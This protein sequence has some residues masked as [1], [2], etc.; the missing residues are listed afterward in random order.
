MISKLLQQDVISL[1]LNNYS[2]CQHKRSDQSKYLYNNNNNKSDNNNDDNN[3]IKSHNNNI[4]NNLNRN[5]RN[6]SDASCQ[7]RGHNQLYGDLQS[8]YTHTFT[9]NNN[10][11][12]NN[13][14]TTNQQY[15]INIKVKIYGIRSNNIFSRH[16]NGYI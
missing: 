3:N 7:I 10:N 4:N 14:Q 13:N 2:I 15:P 6:D 5:Q 1:I 8:N 9:Q 12:N 16:T 11:Q